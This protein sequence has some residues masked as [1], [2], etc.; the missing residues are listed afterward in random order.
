MYFHCLQEHPPIFPVSAAP[1]AGSTVR[2]T[3]EARGHCAPAAAHPDTTLANTAACRP[4][5]EGCRCTAAGR[6]QCAAELKGPGCY[7]LHRATKALQ[8]SLLAVFTHLLSA[9]W[10]VM[11]PHTPAH[12]SQALPVPSVLLRRPSGHPPAPTSYFSSKL[13]AG[14]VSPRHGS[15]P[16][17]SPMSSSSL[18]PGRSQHLCTCCRSC[19]HPRLHPSVCLSP[20]PDC[21]MS[22]DLCNSGP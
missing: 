18:S 15:P 1:T 19:C 3:E 20:P 22:F 21:R 9:V 17:A 4:S 5:Q 8:T 14:A 10:T 16:P 11:A 13:N 6:Q 7:F 12:L 2:F